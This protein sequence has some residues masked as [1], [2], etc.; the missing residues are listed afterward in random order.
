MIALLDASVDWL[1]NEHCAP[2][3]PA[4][5]AAITVH[6]QH[7]LP[8]WSQCTYFLWALFLFCGPLA[9]AFPMTVAGRP[10]CAAPSLTRKPGVTNKFSRSVVLCALLLQT[11]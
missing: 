4:P 3:P 10:N 9:W 11:K 7:C 5:A 1:V 2:R 8:A 6:V